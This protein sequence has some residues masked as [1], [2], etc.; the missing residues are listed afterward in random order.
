MLFYANSIIN[1]INNNIYIAC[2]KACWACHYVLTV[3]QNTR[4]RK[5]KKKNSII[6]NNNDNNKYIYIYTFATTTLI[7]QILR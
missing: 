3:P 1:R 2:P 6:D 7:I 4:D 5:K